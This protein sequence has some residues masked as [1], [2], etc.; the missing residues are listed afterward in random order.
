MDP[1]C[2]NPIAAHLGTARAA[3]AICSVCV[4]VCVCV[5]ARARVQH[6]AYPTATLA[7]EGARETGRKRYEAGGGRRGQEEC[8]RIRERERF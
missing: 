6:L 8:K 5:H 3:P 4:C 1:Q 2:S 7:A